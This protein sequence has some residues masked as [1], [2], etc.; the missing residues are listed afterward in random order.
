MHKKKHSF[1]Y[2]KQLDIVQEKFRVNFL[3]KAFNGQKAMD[4]MVQPETMPKVQ[5]EDWV[6]SNTL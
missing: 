4:L 1:S 3:L 5:L 2:A 6:V